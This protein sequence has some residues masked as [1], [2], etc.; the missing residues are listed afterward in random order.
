MSSN[1]RSVHFRLKTSPKADRNQCVLASGVVVE[2]TATN[3]Y[4][5]LFWALK[6][7][8]NSFAIVTRFDIKTVKSSQVW[9]GIAQ[10]DQSQS[11]GYLDAVYNFGKYGSLDSKA[12]IIP[13]ILAFPAA[14]LVVYA[15]S[16]FYDSATNSPT[17]FENFTAPV[18]PP[19]ADSYAYQPLAEYVAFTDALQPVGLRQ[20]FRTLS[21]I[22][23]EDAIKIVHDTFTATVNSKLAAVPNLQASVT[24]QPVTKQFI[25]QGINNGGNPQGVDISKAPYFWVVEN[26]TWTNAADDKTVNTV[27][28]QITSETNKLLKAKKLD[29]NYLYLNDAGKGQPV[30]QGYPAANLARL[31]TIRNKYDPL[32]IYTNLMPGGWK[33]AA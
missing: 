32:K 6:G 31:K 4:S 16:K 21:S 28:D 27:A 14:Q 26:W 11:A 30:F 13:T 33:V 18:L 20:A 5:D 25:Q 23:N 1:S 24:F 22:V 15:A 29:T 2:A 10:Y 19:V 9:V 17:A 3:S 8:A 7:G 12:A